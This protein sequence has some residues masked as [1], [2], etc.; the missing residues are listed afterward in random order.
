MRCVGDEGRACGARRELRRAKLRR[1]AG[2]VRRSAA[3]SELRCYG[4]P[5]VSFFFRGVAFGSTAAVDSS[6]PQHTEKA[7][8]QIETNNFTHNRQA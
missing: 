2:Q 7:V 6:I 4:A 3:E 8:K 5:L 1:A